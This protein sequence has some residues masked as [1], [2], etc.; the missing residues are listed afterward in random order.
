M[1]AVLRTIFGSDSESD[2]Y[3]SS[4]SDDKS[5]VDLGV[6]P[7]RARDATGDLSN[8]DGWTNQFSGVLVRKINSRL[9]VSSFPKEMYKSSVIFFT[10]P[11]YRVL[12]K[13]YTSMS[14]TS[15]LNGV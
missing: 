3:G 12:W 2:F 14:E 15:S 8:E 11:I 7:D 13:K 9:C 1:A 5:D 6:D 10:N 4:E